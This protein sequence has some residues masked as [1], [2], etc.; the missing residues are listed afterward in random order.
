MSEQQ[1]LQ[2]IF[3]DEPHVYGR[4]PVNAAGR[5][6]LGYGQVELSRNGV[7]FR[8]G[9][10]NAGGPS[11]SGNAYGNVRLLYADG[12]NGQWTNSAGETARGRAIQGGAA[13]GEIVVGDP[14]HPNFRTSFGIGTFFAGNQQAG[15]VTETGARAS[16]VEQEV[17]FG[18][19]VLGD[20]Q[21][22]QVGYSVGVG[23]T[24]RR[25]CIPQPNGAPPIVGRNFG[26]SPWGGGF[27]INGEFRSS[28]AGRL[29]QHSARVRR[30]F[31]CPE[32]VALPPAAESSLLSTA[33]EY[34]QLGIPMSGA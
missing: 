13:R 21:Y 33:H 6:N 26:W 12:G 31:G 23:S 16:V 11:P 18:G 34:E 22:G 14:Q 7:G 10:I 30:M 3:D 29:A 1:G 8:A 4:P 24:Q 27:R 28:T 9:A 32:S 20:Y 2:P 17:G 19:N 15:G 25:I 5:P